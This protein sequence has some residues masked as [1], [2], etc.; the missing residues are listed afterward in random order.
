M[1][2]A[3]WPY[4]VTATIAAL[5][6][7]MWMAFAW[8]GYAL[9]TCGED[10]DID[11]QEEYDQLC[12]AGGTIGDGLILFGSVGAVAMIFLGTIAVRR[13]SWWPLVALAIVLLVTG[14]ALL[15]LG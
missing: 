12:G 9:R 14:T 13:R 2:R 7:A 11:S 3:R 1:Q 10:S 8:L 4:V 15:N 6:F 5:L